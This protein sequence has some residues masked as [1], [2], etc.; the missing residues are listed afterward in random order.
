MLFNYIKNQKKSI[1]SLQNNHKI[2][3]GKILY[4]TLNINKTYVKASTKVKN[5][6]E[7]L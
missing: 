2:L 6:T 4:A 5:F 7:K 1:L 3:F